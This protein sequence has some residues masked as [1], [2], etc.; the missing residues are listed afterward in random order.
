MH[1]MSGVTYKQGYQGV[2]SDFEMARYWLML[3]QKQG[4]GASS[5]IL[6]DPSRWEVSHL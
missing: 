5:Q 1:S 6:N 4:H 2:Q 3:A